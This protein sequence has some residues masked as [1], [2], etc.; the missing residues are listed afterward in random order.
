MTESCP[1]GEQ[2]SKFFAFLFLH[3]LP[4]WLW[5]M[6]E[7][8]NHQDVRSLVVKANKLQALYG[9]LQHGTVGAMDSLDLAVN[10]VKGSS[11][12]G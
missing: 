12:G 9:H 10:A 7:E 5:I 6:L 11:R 1:Q 4:N 3:H 2:Q 8:D